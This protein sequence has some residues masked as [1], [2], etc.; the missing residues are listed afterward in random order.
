MYGIG[1]R[2]DEN[3]FY[4]FRLRG[5]DVDKFI[6]VAVERS[7]ERMLENANRKSDRILRNCKQI[8]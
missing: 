1:I 3:P 4:F 6:G 8:T 7:V 2:F 5:I